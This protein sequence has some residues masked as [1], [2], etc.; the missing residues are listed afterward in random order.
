MG[1]TSHLRWVLQSL[2][3][4]SHELFCVLWHLREASGV[5]GIGSSPGYAL[6]SA[7]TVRGILSSHVLFGTHGSW[8]FLA[9]SSI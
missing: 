8:Y 6:C 1:E 5:A 7:R 4:V 2:S 9:L 3:G